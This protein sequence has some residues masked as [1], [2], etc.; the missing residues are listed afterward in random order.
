MA[1]AICI[2]RGGHLLSSEL[3]GSPQLT[4]TKMPNIDI[5]HIFHL[6]KVQLRLTSRAKIIKLLGP[7][8]TMASLPL[9]LDEG[10]Q[11]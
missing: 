8:S 4:P 7:Y 1:A 2:E 10:T 9:M 5:G 3:H 11:C 6:R